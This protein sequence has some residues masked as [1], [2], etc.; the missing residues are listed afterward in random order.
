MKARTD[1]HYEVRIGDSNSI[2]GR[3][4]EK[5]EA[6]DHCK[7]LMDT[8]PIEYRTNGHGEVFDYGVVKLPQQYNLKGKRIPL[9]HL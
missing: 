7:H 1:I 3:F 4:Y 6:L 9:L 2:G 5:Q 8:E